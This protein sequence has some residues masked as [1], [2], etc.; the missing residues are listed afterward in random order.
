MEEWVEWGS[1]RIPGEYTEDPF[2]EAVYH[3]SEAIRGELAAMM[4]FRF[5]Y[6][7]ALAEETPHAAIAVGRRAQAPL[8]RDIFAPSPPPTVDASW[9][10]WHGGLVAR[11]AL[12]AYQE[13]HLPSG[14]LDN[15]R[16]LVLADALDEA[17]CADPVLLGHLRSRGGHVRGCFVIDALMGRG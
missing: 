9:L 11:L 14:L 1:P 15:D 2:M 10:A 16:L 5:W 6:E 3:A 7:G 17:G 8:V 13:R 12:A 4:E